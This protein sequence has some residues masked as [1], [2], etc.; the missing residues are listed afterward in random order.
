MCAGIRS[1][2]RGSAD[3]L[4]Q[5]FMPPEAGDACHLDR[6][7][8]V[9]DLLTAPP[10]LDVDL[11][12][13]AHVVRRHEV[14][15]VAPQR[16]HDLLRGGVQ[17]IISLT[18]IVELIILDHQVMHAAHRRSDESHA[19]VARVDVHEVGRHGCQHEVAD[20]KTEQVSVKC[21]GG[22]DVG[23]RQEGVP[24]ALRA[25]PEAGD[26]A[27]GFEGCVA[28]LSA[29]DS[30]FTAM[31][32]AS[33]RAASES[34]AAPS[35]TSHPKTWV[36]GS[37]ARSMN[38]RC[39]RSSMR[40]ARIE[41]PRSTGC[42]PMLVVANADQSSRLVEPTPR[43]PKAWISMIRLPNPFTHLRTRRTSGQY[44]EGTLPA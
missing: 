23:E 4:E 18:D 7:C 39:L 31:P 10:A 42:I 16:G 24:H 27:A 34:R 40:K 19:V 43:Y 9:V 5:A 30:R 38:R 6:R 20:A 26:V 8:R 35:A 21:Q 37:M 44:R 3:V 12:R 2:R 36:P 22:I 32:A 11:A 41:P 13:R 25:G 14:V 1:G 33:R 15:G 29:V 17:Q 28:D